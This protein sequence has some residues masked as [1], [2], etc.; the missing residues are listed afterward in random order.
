MSAKIIAFSAAPPRGR[1][2]R[3][4][5]RGADGRAG[6]R[7]TGRSAPESR[8]RPQPPASRSGG[9]SGRCATASTS[10]FQLAR[11]PA[12]FA[13]DPVVD[14]VHGERG[15]PRHRRSRAGRAARQ[16]RSA[17]RATACRHARRGATAGRRSAAPRRRPGRG[18]AA[19]RPPAAGR[20]P[21]RP[22]R[23][24][25]PRRRSFA[26]CDGPASGNRRAEPSS[27]RPNGSGTGGSRLGRRGTD[28]AGSGHQRVTGPAGICNQRHSSSWLGP[29]LVA[30]LLR[31]RRVYLSRQPLAMAPAKT[32]G[33]PGGP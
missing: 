10:R 14:Q 7:A 24:R 13:L 19:R 29:A 27:Q 9:S 25:A 12:P 4:A 26:G 11:R 6:G 18:P 33:G 32:I 21:D 5:R 23:D 31:G 22:A 20:P 17:H 28:G 3:C 8:D 16:S 30:E 2:D 15:A 1:S